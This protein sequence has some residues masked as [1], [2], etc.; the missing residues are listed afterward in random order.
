MSGIHLSSWSN[1]RERSST[2]SL[3][4]RG[5]SAMVLMILSANVLPSCSHLQPGVVD[6]RPRLLH[7]WSDECQIHIQCEGI[8]P[9]PPCPRKALQAMP[10]SPETRDGLSV[11]GRLDF[12]EGLCTMADCST[13]TWRQHCCNSASRKLILVSEAGTVFDLPGFDCSGDESRPT[14]SCTKSGGRSAGRIWRGTSR[15]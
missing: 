5:Y 11:V 2:A 12:G 1:R 6:K 3:S 15:G 13:R 9:L 10:M 8:K 14:R 7:S 4:L